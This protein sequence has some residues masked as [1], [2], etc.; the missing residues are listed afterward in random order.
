MSRV[1]QILKSALER[2]QS[3]NPKYSLRNFAKD[4]AVNP[5]FVSRI[6][7]GKQTVPSSRLE[8]II[9]TLEMDSHTSKMLKIELIRDY[10]KEL[11]IHEKE[12]LK[13]ELWESVVA[14]EVT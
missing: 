11:G 10:M 13:E 14:E 4:L 3:L 7:T 6:L 8:Q 5:S 2:R 9:Q 1:H 12:L